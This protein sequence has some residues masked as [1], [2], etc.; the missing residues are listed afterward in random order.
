[1]YY[2]IFLYC[3][4]LCMTMTF[5]QYIKALKKKIT[6]DR[7]RKKEWNI[8]FNKTC[9][10]LT[11]FMSKIQLCCKIM[12]GRCFKHWT[13]KLTK[14]LI[15]CQSILVINSLCELLYKK[16]IKHKTEPMY[17]CKTELTCWLCSLNTVCNHWLVFE[18]HLAIKS[19]L[20]DW[21]KVLE[22]FFYGVEKQKYH[23]YRHLARQP[24][25]QDYAQVARYF[26]IVIRDVEEISAHLWP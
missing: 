11:Q 22:T 23:V 19:I 2:V 20:K 16:I 6:L 18:Q 4:S 9:T 8:Y 17:V 21:E 25:I 26:S 7:T 14:S 15:F 24:C 12:N 5:I 3:W 1:M 10:L 13:D